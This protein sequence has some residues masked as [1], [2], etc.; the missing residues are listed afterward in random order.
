M[1]FTCCI[2]NFRCV[3]Y[4]TEKP[5]LIPDFMI[6]HVRFYLNEVHQIF[7]RQ[8][9]RWHS[10]ISDRKNEELTLHQGGTAISYEVSFQCTTRK[11]FAFSVLSYL[12]SII[13]NSYLSQGMPKPVSLEGTLLSKH[14]KINAHTCWPLHL[15]QYL[16]RYC[17][18]TSFRLFPSLRHYCFWKSLVRWPQPFLHSISY[19]CNL[20]A[21]VHN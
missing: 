8:W 12:T 20:T 18:R 13:P 7:N 3:I 2:R 16:G 17:I 4:C 14:T 10:T 9:C 11:S 19:S 1:S 15:L 21:K 5:P 6:F